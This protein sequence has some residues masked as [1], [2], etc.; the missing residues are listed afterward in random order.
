[1]VIIQLTGE[2]KYKYIHYPDSKI[3]DIRTNHPWIYQANSAIPVIHTIPLAEQSQVQQR[4]PF[5]SA[6]RS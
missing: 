5:R 3:C 6:T 2:L 1:V 4:F